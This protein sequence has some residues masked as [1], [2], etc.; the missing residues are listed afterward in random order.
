MPLSLLGF[1][2]LNS[3]PNTSFANEEQ[4]IHGGNQP[5]LPDDLHA[6]LALARDNHHLPVYRAADNEASLGAEAANQVLVKPGTLLIPRH[7][8]ISLDRGEPRHRLSL[9]LFLESESSPRE[10]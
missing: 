6:V 10:L 2:P 4:H 8:R 1:D 9:S 3:S 5:Q 7:L